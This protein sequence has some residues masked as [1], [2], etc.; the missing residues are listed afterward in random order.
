MNEIIPLVSF[1]KSGNTW[2]R[3]ILSNLFKKDELFDINFKNI[4]DISSTSHSE[5]HSKMISLLKPNAP[6]FIKEHYSYYD[7]PYKNFKKAIYIYRNGFDTLLSYWHFRNAQNPGMYPNIETF[8][9]YYWNNYRQWGEHLFSWLE[10]EKTIKSHNI[11]AISYEN[12]M[13]NPTETIKKCMDFLGYEFSLEDIKIAIELSSKDKMKKMSGSG[14]FMKSKDKDFHFV[15]SAK[16]GE[17]KNQLSMF[18]KREFIKYDINYKMMMK[19]SYLEDDNEWKEISKIDSLSLMTIFKNK[20][21]NYKY[22]LL[23]K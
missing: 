2:M 21:Y 7:M 1:P 18:C 11:Y 19:Y 23:E 12:L 22:R 13:Q 15:R 20:F 8:T 10:D 14:E 3:F 9:K 4:N 17:S 6:L 16:N 5:D